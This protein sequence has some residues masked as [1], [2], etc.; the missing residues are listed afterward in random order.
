MI[1]HDRLFK[2]LLTT[3]FGEFIDLFLPELARYLEGD[4]IEFLDKEV[5]TDV[6]AGERYEDLIAKAQFQGQESFF[7]IHLFIFASSSN[8][9][10][11]S[12]IWMTQ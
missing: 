2:E 1:D 11:R 5:F 10:H 6:T 4:S 9:S 3:F 8:L 7:L 12:L